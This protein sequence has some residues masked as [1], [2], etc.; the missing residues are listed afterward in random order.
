MYCKIIPNLFYKFGFSCVVLHF[1]RPDSCFCNKNHFMND[2]DLF[3]FFSV[4]VGPHLQHMEVLRL[5]VKSE[6]YLL[7]YTT[8]TA[9]WYLS[10]VCDLHHS[11][12]QCRILNSLSEAR[13]QPES[14]WMLFRFV[15]AELRWE[16]LILT[17]YLHLRPY[18][19]QNL[20][21]VS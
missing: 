18:N 16:L 2:F 13:D 5:G 4:F 15:S 21:T 1:K 11:W 14:S 6:L 8:A 9:M 19:F 17:S 20:L 12:P 10:C 7:A 3:F